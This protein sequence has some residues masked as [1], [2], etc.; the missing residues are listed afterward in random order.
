[1]DA[2]TGV[3]HRSNGLPVVVWF[4]GGGFDSGSTHPIGGGNWWVGKWMNR[5]ESSIASMHIERNPQYFVGQTR[6]GGTSR[7]SAASSW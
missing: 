1:M 4:H 7:P 3:N 5:F 2:Y 6:T